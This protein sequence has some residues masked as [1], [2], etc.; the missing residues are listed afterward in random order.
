MILHHFSFRISLKTVLG[1]VA[2]AGL[3]SGFVVWTMPPDDDAA[4]AELLLERGFDVQVAHESF[5]GL[6]WTEHT[7][8]TK[9][10]FARSPQEFSSDNPPLPIDPEAI[11]AIQACGNLRTLQLEGCN[12]R[13]EDLAALKTRTIRHLSFSNTA[14]DDRFLDQ[15]PPNNTLG[16]LDIHGTR[17]T[18]A[19]LRKLA[20]CQ[21]LMHLE[22]GGPEVT[23][24]FLPVIAKL[25]QLHFLYIA[26]GPLEPHYLACLADSELDIL[27]VAC[28]PSSL[29]VESLLKSNL[30]NINFF[31]PQP[32]D[33]ADRLVIET[34]QTSRH[35]TECR[36]N[37]GPPEFADARANP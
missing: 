15:L 21:A 13:S 29:P 19:G 27:W 12:L 33:A 6:P 7:I 34:L 3:A 23:G 22:V 9:I 28:K 18:D 26:S 32:L 14:I 17:V 4:E 25:P 31:C 24:S 36:V 2:V 35:Q 1:L 8:V 20:G 10:Y 5:W 30:Y 11:A 37:F 16:T